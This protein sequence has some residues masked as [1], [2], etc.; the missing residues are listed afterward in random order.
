M[1]QSKRILTNKHHIGNY[2]SIAAFMPSM[3]WW[4]YA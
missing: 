3:M 1:Q 2:Q 4:E